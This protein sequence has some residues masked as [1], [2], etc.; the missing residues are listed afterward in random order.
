MTR[1]EVDYKEWKLFGFMCPKCKTYNEIIDTSVEGKLS[2][3]V[4]CRK[5][6]M[7]K[8]KIIKGDANGIE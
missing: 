5:V 8:K 3:C 6:S 2:E 1:N 7:L 4:M